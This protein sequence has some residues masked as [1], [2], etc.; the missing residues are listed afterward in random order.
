MRQKFKEC[1]K[2]ISI[3]DDTLE[4][5]GTTTDYQKLHARIV[6]LIL[7]WSVIAIL[8]TYVEI[9]LWRYDY[10]QEITITFSLTYVRLYCS[11]V[12]FISDLIIASILG[13]VHI[14]I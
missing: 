11:H 13:L 7:G 9:A 1:L 8:M 5:L 4:Q 14:Y 3:V 10:N 2:R 12:N 6:W